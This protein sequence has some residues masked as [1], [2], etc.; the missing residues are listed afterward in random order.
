MTVHAEIETFLHT[1]SFPGSTWP[2]GLRTNFGS[3]FGCSLD[4]GPSPTLA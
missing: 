1:W 2:L 4:G 3:S